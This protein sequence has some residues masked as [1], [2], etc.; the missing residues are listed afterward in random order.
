[1]VTQLPEPQTA[2]QDL[3]SDVLPVLDVELSKLPEKYRAP[4]VPCDLQG[5]T[6]REA[7]RHLGWPE[8]T[9]SGRLSRA[10]AAGEAVDAA[11]RGP[12]GWVAGTMGVPESF[13][14]LRAGIAG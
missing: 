5:K 7:A 8:G 12:A 4:I 2:Q 13:V 11:R 14:G 3:W 9:L 6:G 10:R 1:L